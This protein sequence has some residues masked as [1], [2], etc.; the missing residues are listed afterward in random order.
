MV[1]YSNTGYRMEM[2]YNIITPLKMYQRD[3]L[4]LWDREYEPEVEPKL[5]F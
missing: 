5:N 2:D 3:A 4:K 1:H